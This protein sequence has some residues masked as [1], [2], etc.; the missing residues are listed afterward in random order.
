MLLV[1]HQNT[2]QELGLNEGC[3]VRGSGKDRDFAARSANWMRRDYLTSM[4]ERT[5]ARPKKRDNGKKTLVPQN[6]GHSVLKHTVPWNDCRIRHH[7]FPYDPYAQIASVPSY[8]VRPYNLANHGGDGRRC[9]WAW[10]E[11]SWD[12]RAV[13]YRR[14]AWMISGRQGPASQTATR[15]GPRE[16]RGP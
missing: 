15:Y 5:E 12:D 1:V 2:G 11:G 16:E 7:H 13:G 8:A 10:I 4:R 9:Y 3:E 6:G 14:W